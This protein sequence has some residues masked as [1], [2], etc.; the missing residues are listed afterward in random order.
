MLDLNVI[1]KSIIGPDATYWYKYLP[2][3]KG[4][5]ILYCIFPAECVCVCVFQLITFIHTMMA[6][7]KKTKLKTCMV[8]CPLNTVLN[9]NNE[10]EKWIDEDMAEIDVSTES[11]T[12]ERN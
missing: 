8:V 1:F 6:H 11:E 9:W 4:Q 7:A 3:W 12:R 2:A 10:F 5:L